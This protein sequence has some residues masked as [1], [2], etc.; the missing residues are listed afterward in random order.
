MSLAKRCLSAFS[1]ANDR[2]RGELARAGEKR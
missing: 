2:R 1:L